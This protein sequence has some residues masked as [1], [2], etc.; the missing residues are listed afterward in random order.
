LEQSRRRSGRDT[1]RRILDHA[2]W[3]VKRLTHEVSPRQLP[4][5]HDHDGGPKARS[6]N[7]SV[8]NRRSSPLDRRLLC[9]PNKGWSQSRNH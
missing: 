3:Q 9:S 5:D 1:E 7:I 4:T 8:I 6:A 2:L